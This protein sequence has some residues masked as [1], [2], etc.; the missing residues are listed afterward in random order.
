[1]ILFKNA[2]LKKSSQFNKVKSV[3]IFFL[4]K[5][6]SR[7]KLKNISMKTP[8]ILI[9]FTIFVCL[10][11]TG[12]SQQKSY[13]NPDQIEIPFKK[14]V[15]DNG[16][17][18]IVHED[19]KAP[20]VAVN[21]WYHVGSKNE[22]P[23]R[24]GFAHLFEHLM[25]NGSENFNKD[26]F[27]ALE[28]IGATDLNGTTNNDRTNYFQNVPTAGLD[29]VLFLESDRMGH[30]VGAID[31]AKLDEQRGVVQN[32]KRQG[33]NQPYGREE[34]IITQATYPK[35]HPYSW[36]V[37]GSME[38]L[39]AA[40]LN[41]VKEWFKTYYG[42]NNAV[43]SIAGDV[44]ADDILAR[45]KKYFGDIP[46][47]PSLSRPV[48]N[49][50][51]R[52]ENT[53]GYYE[54][55]VPE[56]KITMVWN[57]PQWGT[58][59][60]TLLDLATDVLAAGKTSR[61]YKKLVYEDQTASRAIAAIDPKE[62]G[63]NLYLEATVKPGKSAEDVEKTM[64][65]ILKEFIEKGPTQDEL[66][67]VRSN[68]FSNFLKGIER[69]G[70]FGGK[71]DILASNQVY[72]GS[73]DF[74]KNTL[75]FVAEATVADMQK[76]CKEWL[77]A[78]K[79][80]LVCKPFP[81]LQAD[82]KGV[83]RSKLP[84]LGVPVPSSFPDLQK[85]TLKNGLNVLLAQRKGVPTIVGK[86]VVNAGY[87]TDA[88]AKAGLAS[89]AMDMLDE[90]TKTMN[91]LQIS[92]RMQLLG[93]TINAGS[94]LDASYV[95]FTTLK[96]T[97]DPTLDL[98]SEILL[99]PAFPQKEF[100]R[101]KKD[102]L[103]NIER[104]KSD[105]FGMALRVFPKVLYGQGHAY[106]NPIRGSGY[107]ATVK[108]ITPEEIQK[109]YNT[110]IKPNNAT[111]VVVGDVQMA[112]LVSKLETR[113][114]AWKK[115][116]VPKN[117]I[118][119]IK[120]GAGKKIYLIDRPESIQSLIIAGYLT[121]PY[122]QISQPALDAMNN[123]LGGDFISRLNL[124]LRED[125]HWSYGA[126]SLVWDAKG[127][128]PFLAYV[129]VQLDKTKESIQEINKELTS[130]NSDKPVLD[131]EFIRVQRNMTLQLPGMWETNN[132]VA[133]SVAEEVKFGLSQ[134]YYKTY[135]AKVRKLTRDELQQISKEVVK[136]ELVNWFVVG[137]KS[138]ILPGLKDLGYEIIEVDADGNPIK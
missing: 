87:S 74:Y 32:E 22:K 45:V 113:L 116:D 135:D 36:T 24:T 129:S 77:D 103:D 117:A 86:L 97:F 6:V 44:T 68:Y 51:R 105:P 38:D 4:R 69:I 49:T 66:D 55:H 137:D 81:S 130:I 47:G 115:G 23:G 120:V 83:D 11:V 111:L 25:F 70:G 18:L 93:A 108:S 1:M 126:G 34:E 16:L 33:E 43:L 82:E 84:E 19:H 78:G 110:W 21:I 37:I 40:S 48:M 118:P 109:F 39:N 53:R 65:D 124:N 132:S 134:D 58:R 14:F 101:L 27:Q 56:A 88:T 79:F 46:P 138:K 31:Q 54:D 114:S 42:P 80:V 127:Q 59:E 96:Q 104:E 106:G 63:A 92:E 90:G 99:N 8:R 107:E 20:I 2:W 122:G 131:E 75:K 85:A 15:L 9:A 10:S 119:Q 61:L 62:I 26:Y 136:P 73:P 91:T 41:D 57:V 17:T 112:D 72:G 50:A 98:F 133:G 30:L 128:R 100:D 52:I 13:F 60:E 89:L 3:L 121:T 76:V 28:A 35:G 102:H 95:N 125:K 7:S 71:S 29:Q 64:N 67:R 123:I 12:F 5:F 94:D